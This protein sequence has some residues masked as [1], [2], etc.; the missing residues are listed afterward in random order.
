MNITETGSLAIGGCDTRELVEQF[1]TPLMIVDEAE[2]RRKCREYRTAF[3]G[4]GIENE[5]IYASKAF[6]TMAMCKMIEEEGLGL[7]VVSGGELY[8]AQAANFPTK[9]VYFHGNNKTPRELAMAL[10]AGIGRFMID[11]LQELQILDHLAA[12]RG[13][14]ADVIF[15]VT[16]GIEAHTHEFIQTGQLDSKFGMGV[17]NGVAYDLIRQAMELSHI[18]IRGLHCHIG[19]Q[20]FNLESFA[21]TVEI[22]MDFMGELRDGLGLTIR[23]LDLGGGVGIPYTA[24]EEEV[25]IREY[26]L[27]VADTLQRKSAELNLPVPKVINEPGRSIIATAGTTLYTIGTIKEIPGIRTYV[28]VDGGMTDNIRPALYG[29]KYEALIAN[30]ALARPVQTVTITGRACESGDMLI[31]DLE[32]PNVEAGDILAVS[33]TGAYTYAMSSNYNALP[34]LAIVLVNDGNADVIVRRETYHDLIRRDRL[35]QHLE[36]VETLNDEMAS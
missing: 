27:T 36:T 35:P 29:A 20:I 25:S 1:G 11:N 14:K 17:S 26:A 10:E 30:K 6:L 16:P 9:K 28:A 18:R 12:E 5:T 21:R 13:M 34:R 19:S 24:S 23:E 33:C 7:D 3:R 15:R 22:M 8:I 32:I 4:T 2:V 31:H